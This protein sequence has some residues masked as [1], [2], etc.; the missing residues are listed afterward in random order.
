MQKDMYSP[1]L[2]VRYKLTQLP[3]QQNQER[4]KSFSDMLPSEIWIQKRRFWELLRNR[5][6]T[7]RTVQ[8]HPARSY[9]GEYVYVLCLCLYMYVSFFVCVNV[10]IWATKSMFLFLRVCFFVSWPACL[11]AFLCLCFVSTIWN[12]LLVHL[13]QIDAITINPTRPYH[14]Q[15]TRDNSTLSISDK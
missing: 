14:C 7:R 10:C 1:S 5:R 13:R 3:Q 15:T 2:K 11:Y 6:L 8:C 9:I 12:S 4:S